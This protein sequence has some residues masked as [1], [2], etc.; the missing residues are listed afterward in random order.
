MTI[1]AYAIF[2][3][4][5]TAAKGVDALIENDFTI[6]DICVLCR[7]G[8][9]GTPIEELPVDVKT[10]IGP[11]MAIGAAL[12]VAGGALVALGGG[13]LAAGPLLTLLQG[14]FTGGAAGLFAGFV[15]G[16]GYL[17]ETIDFPHHH[18]HRLEHGA[19]LVGVM[20][21][22]RARIDSAKR[23]LKGAGA[24]EVH[25]RTRRQADHELERK[26]V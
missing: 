17:H 25:V 3:T 24:P 11:G 21:S 8:P 19:V 4:H 1:L 16:L 10:G 14:T 6:K 7:E 9:E 15:G 5:K 13:L 18:R 22:K 26:H 20:S 12:G 2:D 23:A